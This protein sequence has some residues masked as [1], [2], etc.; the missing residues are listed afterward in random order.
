MVIV[1]LLYFLHS[2]IN[3]FWDSFSLSIMSGLILSLC[4]LLFILQVEKKEFQKLPL[5]GRFVGR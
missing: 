3:T 2:G 4:F 5:V 1:V